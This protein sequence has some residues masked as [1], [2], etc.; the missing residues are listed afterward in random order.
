MAPG[1]RDL[2][3][4]AMGGY[5][6]D[7]DLEDVRLLDYYDNRG[8]AAEAPTSDGQR[9]LLVRVTGMTCAACSSSVE[10]AL[11]A[12]PGVSRASVALLQNKVDVVFDPRIASVGSRRLIFAFLFFFV[13]VW[14]G[15]F[16]FPFFLFVLDCRVGSGNQMVLALM[17]L[18]FVIFDF[19]VDA[20][21]LNYCLWVHRL[22]VLRMIN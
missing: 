17:D 7:V 19:G 15:D 9:S 3:L 2:E 6:A 18:Y 5:P 16:S 8:A 20:V 14:G 22:T 4:G 10:S 21:S 12:V 13:C 1:G 11:S